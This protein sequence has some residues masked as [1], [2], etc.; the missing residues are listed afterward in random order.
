M[1]VGPIPYERLDAEAMAN[2]EAMRPD[3]LALQPDH[4]AMA[5]A[6]SNQSR[7]RMLEALQLIAKYQSE[8]VSPQCACRTGCSHCC[9]MSVSVGIL[10]ARAIAKH[11]GIQYSKPGPSTVEED[12]VK[13]TG[14]PCPF[15]ENSKCKVYPVR[16]LACSTYFN[17]SN[18]SEICDLK[19]HPNHDVP[20]LNTTVFHLAQVLALGEGLSDIRNW[21]PNAQT[22]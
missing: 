19:A 1:T 15:L 21:F 22:A 16:P 11:L 3:L 6:N 13:Y 14:V 2:L 5:I 17:M 7:V 10:E 4:K 9:N 18:T 12:R 8:I 20:G